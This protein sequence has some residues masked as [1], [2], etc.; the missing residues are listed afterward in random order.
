M[1]AMKSRLRQVP[2]MEMILLDWTRMGKTYCLAGAVA[3][4]GSWRVVRPLPASAGEPVRKFGWS[5]FLLDGHSRWEIFELIYP[6]NLRPEPPHVEDLRVR[7]LRPRNRVATPVQRRAI[8]TATLVEPPL[9]GADLSTTY[10]SA[11]LPPNRGTRSLATIL[12]PTDRIT[13]STSCR[14][15]AVEPDTRVVLPVPGLGE[16]FLPVKDHHLLARAERASRQLDSRLRE[17]TLAVQQ[18]GAMVAVRLGLSRAFQGNPGRA[19]A[20]CWLMADGFFSATD[21]QP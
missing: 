17:L 20:V 1:A 8:L 18:M 3:D 2:A 16:R 4:G 14:E 9:F 15:G 11:Y 5:P 13:F 7:A 6:Q 12:A 19:P 10:A 21:P